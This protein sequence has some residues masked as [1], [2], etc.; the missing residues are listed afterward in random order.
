MISIDPVFAENEYNIL[1]KLR[2]DF[3]T[4]VLIIFWPIFENKRFCS[5]RYFWEK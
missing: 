1:R 2:A 5:L 4:V 3:L